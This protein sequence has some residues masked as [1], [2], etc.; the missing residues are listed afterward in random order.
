LLDEN[1][2]ALLKKAVQRAKAGDVP[3]LK[4]LLGSLLP[5][6]RLICFEFP[7]LEFADD[8][9]EV[10]GCVTRAVSEGEITPSEGAALAA[11]VNSYAKAIDLADVVKR[12][13]A[14]EVKLRP[15][16]SR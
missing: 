12:L 7:R 5:K 4:F 16:R 6:D 2:E 14:L 13:D 10:L 11:L 1:A 8:A 3:M 15:H 9:V